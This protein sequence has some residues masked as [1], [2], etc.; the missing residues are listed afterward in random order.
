MMGR[1]AGAVRKISYESKKGGMVA[2]A[3]KF[4]KVPKKML[5]PIIATVT[6][7]MCVD[8]LMNRECLIIKRRDSLVYEGVLQRQTIDSLETSIYG[9]FQKMNMREYMEENNP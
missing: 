9:E 6:I 2:R 3:L 4:M 5:F 1:L 7:Y 8:W